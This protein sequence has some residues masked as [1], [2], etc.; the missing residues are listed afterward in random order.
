MDKEVL[1]IAIIATG[2]IVV[3]SMLAWG[4]FK[5]KKY[6][7]NFALDEDDVEPEKLNVPE[8]DE[9]EE[10]IEPL[11]SAFDHSESYYSNDEDDEQ[12]DFEPASQRTTTPE[13]I[14]FCLVAK[15]SQGFNGSDLARGFRIAGL[16]YG[17]LKIFER[18]DERNQLVDYGVACMVEPGTF[19]NTNLDE[20]HCPGIVFF[21]QPNALDDA[22]AVFD[23]YIETIRMLAIELDGTIFDHQ[24]NLLT[25][26]TVRAIRQSL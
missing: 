4:Y 26:E 8:H 15:D 17:S 2:L 18:I 5:D 7:V 6:H 3:V 10:Y 13:I 19:P 9:P 24:R 1:R 23:D 21:M 20:F 11:G 25:D 12:D 16:K 14:Q 22:V